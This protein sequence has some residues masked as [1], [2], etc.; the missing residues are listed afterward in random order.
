MSVQYINLAEGSTAKL[1]GSIIDNGDVKIWKKERE[2]YYTFLF[3]DLRMS[4]PDS[5]A[6]LSWSIACYQMNMT[7]RPQAFW[8]ETDSS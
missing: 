2:M 7:Y 4:S 5:F 8:P 1:Y 3:Q 6:K